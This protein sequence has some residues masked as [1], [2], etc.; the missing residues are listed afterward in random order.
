MSL[1]CL[2]KGSRLFGMCADSTAAISQL[3]LPP[4]EWLCDLHHTE[5]SGTQQGIGSSLF[6]QT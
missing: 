3:S 6:T 4:G 5:E 1:N 2:P